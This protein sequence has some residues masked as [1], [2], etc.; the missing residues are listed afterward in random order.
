MRI[1]FAQSL[2]IAAVAALALAACGSSSKSSSSSNTTA[3]AAAVTTTPPTTGASSG[4]TPTVELTT[5]TVKDFGSQK[6]LADGKGMTLY[7]SDKDT[8]GKSNCTGACAAA[9]PTVAVTG[10]PNVGAGL[11]ASMFTAITG[12][13]GNKILAVNGKP[14]YTWKADTSAGMTTG[15]GVNG[16]Y[17]VNAKGEKLDKD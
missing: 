16:F 13:D 3:P 15:Q 17:V 14:L 1:R 6:I 8:A 4:G 12:P 10:T 2:A 7:I 9:W 11:T 5:A